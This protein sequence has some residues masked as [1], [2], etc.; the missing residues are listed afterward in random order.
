MFILPLNY[1]NSL[2][3]SKIK[4]RKDKRPLQISFEIFIHQQNLTKKKIPAL[5]KLPC[6]NNITENN[7]S[8]KAGSLIG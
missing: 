3:S 1:N 6:S 4:T 2:V 5:I 8:T 7:F